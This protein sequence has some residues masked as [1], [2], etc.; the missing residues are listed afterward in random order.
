MTHNLQATFE[1]L[2]HEL[3]EVNQNEE[4]L[5]KNFAELTELKHILRKTQQ[6][7]E[8]VSLNLLLC[9]ACFLSCVVFVYCFI[10]L[11]FVGSQSICV[12]L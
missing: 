2:E 9:L 6:F 10:I 3:R 5:K 7:F 1:K 8:E 12:F 11:S 4:M